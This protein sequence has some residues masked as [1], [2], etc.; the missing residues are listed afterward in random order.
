[1]GRVYF[2]AERANIR[3]KKIEVLGVGMFGA[4][5]ILSAAALMVQAAQQKV[6]KNNLIA[7]SNA[8]IDYRA[9]KPGTFRK[10]TSVVIRTRVTKASIRS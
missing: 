2:D 8:F 9:M 7:G 3:T 4:G 10:I 5:L 1:M 6:D